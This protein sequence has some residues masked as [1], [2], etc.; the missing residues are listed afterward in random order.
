MNDKKPCCMV[1]LLDSMEICNYNESE[2]KINTY[3]LIIFE[4]DNKSDNVK[5]LLNI[6][7]KE[8]K[9]NVKLN[10]CR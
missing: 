7:K 8:T 1:N 4:K 2:S 5:A 9:Y 6:N 3:L 10:E